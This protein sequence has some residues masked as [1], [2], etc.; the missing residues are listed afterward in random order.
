[1][2]WVLW[3]VSPVF[4]TLSISSLYPAAAS[5]NPH[6][7]LLQQNW[8]FLLLCSYTNAVRDRIPTPKILNVKK[9]LAKGIKLLRA[10][11]SKRVNTYFFLH[12]RVAN[13]VTFCSNFSLPAVDMRKRKSNSCFKSWLLNYLS[14][15]WLCSQWTQ[16]KQNFVLVTWE[17]HC[18]AP[19]TKHNCMWVWIQQLCSMVSCFLADIPFSILVSY[20]CRVLFLCLLSFPSFSVLPIQ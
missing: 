13:P 6:P 5:A 19:S 9:T 7:Q 15:C 8:Y 10:E 20:F 3:T 17:A 11:D 12:L 18:H 2:L 1:M 16:D 4:P 14:S